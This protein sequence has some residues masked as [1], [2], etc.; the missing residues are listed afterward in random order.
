LATQEWQVER[1]ALPAEEK[2]LT[3]RGDELTKQR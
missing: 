1:E 2:E 3:H